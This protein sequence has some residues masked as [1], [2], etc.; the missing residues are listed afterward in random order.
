MRFTPAMVADA[1]V[2]LHF[3]LAHCAE[4]SSADSKLLATLRED[5]DV[6]AAQRE[7]SAGLASLAGSLPADVAEALNPI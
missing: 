7:R 3:A 1:K 4:L 5:P 6:Q 2:A